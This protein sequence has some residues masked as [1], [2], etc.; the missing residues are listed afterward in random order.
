MKALRKLPAQ[1]RA[2]WKGAA[3]RRANRSV[4][5]GLEALER[6]DV[7]AGLYSQVAVPYGGATYLFGLTVNGQVEESFDLGNSW[8]VLTSA[9]ANVTSLVAGNGGLYMLANTGALNNTVWLYGLAG[10]T[11][12]ALTDGSTYA[13]ALVGALGNLYMLGSEGA[14]YQTVW[15]YSGSGT[16]W[17]RVTGSNTSAMALVA[18]NGGLYMLG[19][20]NGAA[21]GTVWQYTGSGS[22]W[23]AITGS[24]TNATALVSVPGNVDMLGSNNGATNETVWQYSGSGTNWTALTGSNTQALQIVSGC[25]NLYMV[26]NNGGANQVWQY[27]GPGTNWTALT[28]AALQDGLTD[29]G[30]AMAHP[31]ADSAYNPVSGTLFEPPASSNPSIPRVSYLDV[32]QGAESDCWLLASLAATAVQRPGVIRHMFIDDGPAIENGSTVEVYS[33]R[34]FT[35][36]GTPEYVTVDNEL[37]SSGDYDHPVGGS[38]AVN[39][40]ASPV[41]WVA[42]AEKA[43]AEAGASG[44]VTARIAYSDAYDALGNVADANGNAGGNPD[45][46]LSAITGQPPTSYNYVHPGADVASAWNAGQP[47][48][49][50]TPPT[51]GPYASSYIVSWHC[52]AVVGYNSSASLPFEVFNPWGTDAAGWAP[53]HRNTIWGLFVADGTF[54]KANFSSEHFGGAAPN[55]A[56]IHS[57]TDAVF[58]GAIPVVGSPG[59]GNPA[60]VSEAAN[61]L[62][63]TVTVSGSILNRNE[64]SGLPTLGVAVRRRV[65]DLF[66]LSSDDALDLWPLEA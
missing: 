5:P 62:P 30:P 8:T 63:A 3:C 49:L 22:N 51:P 18:G 46:A 29:W 31:A 14:A 11:W 19:S 33:V 1:V 25:G 17:N 42:L 28:G 39:G 35:S 58:A 23:T 52:Y 6:R 9:S 64:N 45:W 2:W 43:Y 15:Q 48:V 27:S 37:P 40:S 13:T 44:Y 56:P 24:N 41:L 57:F 36:S 12:T 7:P 16:T 54:L 21:Y 10:G 47:I 38:G 32:E 34:F 65:T 20:N 53:G 55:G 50:C 60:L 26:G 61:R 59:Q 4:R 66:L